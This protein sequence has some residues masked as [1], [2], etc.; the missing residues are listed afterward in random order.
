MLTGVLA[1]TALATLPLNAP[2]APKRVL[3]ATVIPA[4]KA[5][6]RLTIVMIVPMAKQ[7]EPAR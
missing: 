6:H 2:E 4:M 7:I 3:V 5:V 1:G